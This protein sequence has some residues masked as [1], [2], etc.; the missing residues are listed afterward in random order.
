MQYNLINAGLV[1]EGGGLRG[2]FTAGVLRRLMDEGLW[3][4]SVYGVSMGACNGANYVARQPERNRIVNIRFVNDPR[5]LS[6]RRLIRGKDLFG[7]EFI[8]QIIPRR[9]IPFDYAAFRDSPVKFWV[10]LTDCVAGEAV[11]LE[12]GEFAQ[13]DDS[14][15]A[16]FRATASL[17]VISAPVRHA[18]RIVMDGGIA[19]PIPVRICLE[20]GHAKRVIVLTQPAGYAKKPSRSGWACRLRHSELAGMHGMLACRHDVYNSALAAIQDMEAR[21][22]AFVIRPET[23]MGVGR[24]CRR[25]KR[26]YDLYDHGYFMAESRMQALREYLNP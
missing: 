5:Y 24:I 14:V 2:V 11:W 19:D 18:G 26:L 15:D 13:S 25:P 6:W 10:G 20:Q 21:G 22:E 1:L 8:F 23:T 12:K 9:I 16:V 7:M 4:S 17:P 3:F